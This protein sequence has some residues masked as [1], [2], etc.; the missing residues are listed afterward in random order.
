MRLQPQLSTQV[1]EPV[2]IQSATPALT[3]P[4]L[5]TTALQVRQSLQLADLL[6]TTVSRLRQTL[7]ADRVLVYRTEVNKT[8]A[9]IEED[10]ADAWERLK[11]KK[12]FD[13][14]FSKYWQSLY[15]KGRIQSIADIHSGDLNPCYVEFLERLQVKASLVV[16]I[17]SRTPNHQEPL[18]RF[19]LEKQESQCFQ[20]WGLLVIQQCAAPRQWQ[21]SEIDLVDQ[22]AVQ[23]EI[24]VHQ[25]ELH[26]AFQI[27]I[28][29]RKS[30]EQELREW[31]DSFELKKYTCSLESQAKIESLQHE[32]VKG[33]FVERKLL[34]QKLL[35]QSTLDSISDG[36]ISTDPKGNIRY[37]N[38]AAEQL[39]GWSLEEVIGMPLTDVFKAVNELTRQ[40]VSN[41]V[42]K[43]L[44]SGLMETLASNT[45]LISRDGTEYPI[46]DSAASVCARNGEIIGA[47]FTLR[48]VTQARNLAR[49][50]SWQA[51]HDELTGLFNRRSFKQHLTD[52]LV[53]ARTQK[54]TH[55]LCYLDLDRFK[56][57][58]DTCGHEAGDQLLQQVT[59]LLQQRI[60]LTDTLA[61]LGGDEFG[62][63]LNQ[64]SLEQA[65]QVADALR[66]LIQDF[67][68]VWNHRTFKI[69][70]SIGL[71]S[72]DKSSA[73]LDALL[74]SADAACYA[75]KEKGR[76]CIYTY[77]AHDDTLTQHQTEKEWIFRIDQALNENRFQL[78]HQTITPLSHG[79]KAKRSEVLLRL[80]GEDGELISPQQ[81]IPAA[82]RYHLISAI[83]QWVIKS[84][85][86]GYQTFAQSSQAEPPE[87]LYNINLSG[88]SINDS[89]FLEFFKHQLAEHQVPPQTI[90]FEITETTAIA[91]L[92]SASH[93]MHAVKDLGCSFALDDFGSGMSSLSYLK[94]LPI[95]YLKIDGGFVKDIDSDRMDYAM[96]EAFN[97][98]SHFMG[99]QT[100]AECVENKST[101]NTLKNIGVDYAQGFCISKPRPLIFSS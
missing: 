83:D 64:C 62:L 80:V 61:R 37:I 16:P 97:N 65:E 82:E 79:S 58:N 25:S 96:V 72:I 48:D 7:R 95:D 12:I 18:S 14:H 100:I 36:V 26:E 90:C 45:V 78:Y 33:K 46:E 66:K 54:Q 92:K 55:T 87:C 11:G 69:G 75:A 53:Q 81:F 21:S 34:E 59:T 71:V 2:S 31:K 93:M 8:G 13:P 98:L 51:N 60:R 22:I 89:H 28:T 63:L 56:I 73:N 30:A 77:Q 50:L 29:L 85:L 3:H 17:L 15:E 47:V 52:A 24:A 5:I 19:E 39:I 4:L 32:V 67:K 101:L 43:V 94:H 10:T 86:S 44:K 27:E 23:M 91:N 41:P 1:Q 76:N 6:A 38:P 42:L 40:P 84:F 68:F 74:K 9:V 20:L 49:Q 35:V 57:I 88:G 70:V 99:I